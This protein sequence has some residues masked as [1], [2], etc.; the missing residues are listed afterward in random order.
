MTDDI[1]TRLREKFQGQMPI[2]LEAADEIERL[3]NLASELIKYVSHDARCRR[4]WPFA[5]GGC[6]T[7]K[8][9]E[10]YKKVVNESV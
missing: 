3:R 1:V 6:P 10:E 5:K 8:V 7:C 4:D 9:L 2:C